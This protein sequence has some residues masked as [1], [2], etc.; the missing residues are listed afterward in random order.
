MNA[1]RGYVVEAVN[2]G[3]QLGTEFSVVIETLE[4]S[5]GEVLV[6]DSPSGSGK[7]TVLGL[8]AGAIPSLDFDGRKH[9]I[10]GHTLP[11]HLPESFH[12]G[13]KELGFVLQ[14]GTLVPYLS[15]AE[16]IA[17]PARIAKLPAESGWTSA[18]IARLGLSGLETRLP[19]EVSVGQR[20]RAA[21]VRAMAT[22]PKLLLMDEPVSAL[23]PANVRQVEELILAIAADA[24]SAV[25]I[26]SHQVARSAFAD[27]RKARHRIYRSDGMTYS[28]FDAPTTA[29]RGA[30]A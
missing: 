15:L 30:A 7:S 6:L 14:T 1:P 9:I 16:N 28:L 12:P 22:R 20:Q 24:G 19:S 23:D 29:D 21:I 25:I 11:R 18:L 8:I 27:H 2:L 4:L 10:A 17:L 3:C 13:P 26:A 5:R